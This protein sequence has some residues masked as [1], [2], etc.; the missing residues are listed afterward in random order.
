MKNNY[1]L[2]ELLF[3]NNLF[4]LIFT[5]LESNFLLKYSLQIANFILNITSLLFNYPN[6]QEIKFDMFNK[7]ILFKTGFGM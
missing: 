5:L 4:I 6:F 7:I 3:Y 1:I 2:Y